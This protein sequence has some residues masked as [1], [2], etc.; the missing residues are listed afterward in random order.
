MNDPRRPQRFGPLYPGTGRPDRRF[1]QSADRRPGL[2][3]P[4]AV[5]IHV[6]RLRFPAVVSRRA[7]AK[8]S[9]VAPRPPRGQSDPTAAA[10]LAIRPAPTGRISPDGLTPPP[11]QG[12]RTP[13]WLWFAAGSAV[14][15]VVA[16]VIALVIANGSVKKQTAIEPLPPMPGPSPTRPTTT[17][18]TPP[19]PSAAPAPTTTTG[20]PSETVAGAMQT[21]VYDVTGEG[22][23]I[24]IT[25]MDSGNVIQTEFNVA[26]PWRKEVSLSK[27]SLHPAS[28]TIVNIGHNVTCS[29]TVA[30]V[31][32]RQ[33][34]G[35][36]LTI[37]DAPS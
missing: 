28:V 16:L 35:A 18:P 26:L 22:R 29:V 32:V 5:C 10:V 37:C 19:S 12:P 4:V 27:S 24:S 33:R 3:R 6:R 30:G 8:A 9:P 20:T 25:Y 34:T 17:T 15:L 31:Q 2:R 13:R 36:G 14:L 1:P 7:P 21:V 11:P 23:A